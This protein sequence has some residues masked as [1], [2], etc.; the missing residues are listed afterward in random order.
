MDSC[1]AEATRIPGNTEFAPGHLELFGS[2][3]GFILDPPL[4]R[5]ESSN[6]CR[7]QT[8]AL[9]VWSIERRITAQPGPPLGNG[10]VDEITESLA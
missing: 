9:S 3:P 7:T 8:E 5:H 1:A 4:L 10:F 6:R 2:S